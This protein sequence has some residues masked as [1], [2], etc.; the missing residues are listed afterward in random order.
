MSEENSFARCFPNNWRNQMDQENDIQSCRKLLNEIADMCEHASLT[1]SLSSGSKR[2]AQR[3]N[4]VLEH[5][6]MTGTVPQG[7]FTPIPEDAD[8]G[9][10]GVEARMLGS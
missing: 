10:I 8:Y 3:F 7:L 5:L 2:T 6:S 9:E 4:T 1:G